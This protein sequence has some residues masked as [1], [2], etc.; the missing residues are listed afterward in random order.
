MIQVSIATLNQPINKETYIWDTFN[1][2]STVIKI[3]NSTY[4]WG[5]DN[6]DITNI[7]KTYL[8]IQFYIQVLV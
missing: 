3:T 4:N 7:S 6:Y 8:I 1:I 5:N 2:K